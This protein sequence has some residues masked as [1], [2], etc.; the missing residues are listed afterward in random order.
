[1]PRSLDLPAWTGAARVFARRIAPAAALPHPL[2]DDCSRWAGARSP[3][4]Q[5]GRVPGARRFA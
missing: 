1:V 5:E 4:P 2:G 3:R